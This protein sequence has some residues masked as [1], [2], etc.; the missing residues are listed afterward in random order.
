M[1]MESSPANASDEANALLKRR[2]NL[3][4]F[5]AAL[6]VYASVAFWQAIAEP[7]IPLEV[8]VK[9]VRYTL[10]IGDKQGR[11][12]VVECIFRRIRLL[13]ERW[14]YR[15][16]GTLTLPAEEQQALLHDI[17]ADLYE[18][19]LRALLDPTRTFWEENFLHCLYFERKHVYTSYMKREG[20]W[21]TQCTRIPRTLVDSLERLLQ[22]RSE[23]TS[24]SL[25]VIDERAQQMLL[26]VELSDLLPIVL[27]LPEKLKAVILLIFWEGHSEKEAAR[28]LHVTDRTVRN[29]LHT[30]LRLLRAEL[31]T[32]KEH[33]SH[34]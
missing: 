1:D 9:V 30:A 31:M 33:L 17:C 34:A 26:S 27:H 18:H 5:Y 19:L 12:R 20:R 16:I 29:R 8:L 25:E 15:V 2:A 3:A 22:H 14:A 6:P 28:T 32:E 13:N 4:E 21:H 11:E 23:H 24:S 10:Q 7:E